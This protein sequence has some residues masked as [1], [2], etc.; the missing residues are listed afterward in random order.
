MAG[1]RDVDRGIMQLA[2]LGGCPAT[3]IRAVCTVL[4]IFRK[5]AVNMPADISLAGPGRR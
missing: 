5:Q 2:W 3:S 1:Y 4:Q